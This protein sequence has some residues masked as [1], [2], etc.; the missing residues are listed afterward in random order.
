VRQE[1]TAGFGGKPKCALTGVIADVEQIVKF[2]QR[3]WRAFFSPRISSFGACHQGTSPPIGRGITQST[4]KR[5]AR[6][7]VVCPRSQ[8]ECWIQRK[9][10]GVV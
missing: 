3:A 9:A 4:E 7:C 6:V 8:R 5:L 2:G 1:Q 10:F